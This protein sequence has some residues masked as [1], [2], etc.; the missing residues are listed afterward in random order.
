MFYFQI[1]G[2][3]CTYMILR[4]FKDGFHPTALSSTKTMAQYQ[5]LDPQ[6]TQTVVVKNNGTEDKVMVLTSQESQL[7]V[8]NVVHYIWYKNTPTEFRF[9]KALCVLSAFKH[10]KPDAV[11]FHTNKP[12][13][14]KYFET[15]KKNPV[16]KVNFY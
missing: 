13:R 11:Y 10:L 16:F 15:L 6:N 9:D 3:I 5:E 12:P 4:F 2:F 1:L 7:K 8:P 14:G